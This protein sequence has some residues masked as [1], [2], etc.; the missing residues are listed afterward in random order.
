MAFSSIQKDSE[1]EKNKKK[2]APQRLDRTFVVHI[3]LTIIVDFIKGIKVNIPFSSVIGR[4]EGILFF[5][6]FRK[7]P[8]A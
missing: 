1:C 6:H 7:M 4:G 5:K 3:L 2:N 8:Q